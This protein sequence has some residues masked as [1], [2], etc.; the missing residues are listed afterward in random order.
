[1]PFKSPAWKKCTFLS[2]N[3]MYLISLRGET[4]ITS[5]AAVHPEAGV[6]SGPHF[7]SSPQC[8]HIYFGCDSGSLEEV[9]VFFFPSSQWALYQECKNMDLTYTLQNEYICTLIGS[10]YLTG[11]FYYLPTSSPDLCVRSVSLLVAWLWFVLQT[12]G[13]QLAC[14]VVLVTVFHVDRDRDDPTIPWECTRKADGSVI[15]AICV[16]WPEGEMKTV[17]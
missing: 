9:K 1:M 13:S 15:W 7:C 17:T 6:G 16:L 4:T 5:T 12:I 14:P 3:H 2:H 10:P 11:G 8:S